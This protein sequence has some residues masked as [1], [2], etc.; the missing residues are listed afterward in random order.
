MK[1][2]TLLEVLLSVAI[3]GIMFG[4][5]APVYQSLQVRNDRD[6]ALSTVT[7]TLRR[8]Q[9]LSQAVDS[10]LTWGV[11]VQTGSIVLFKGAAYASR[12]S[13]FDETFDLPASLTPSGLSEVVFSKMTGLPQQTGTLTLSTTT[14]EA[15][16]ITINSMGMIDY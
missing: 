1:G 7:Q 8:A 4:I 10:D 5:S 15:K 13:G 2:F 14:N 11:K 16:T 6:V 12:I 3:V 9:L